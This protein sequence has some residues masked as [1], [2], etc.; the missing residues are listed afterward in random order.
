MGKVGRYRVLPK[1]DAMLT[2]TTKREVLNAVRRARL[3]SGDLYRLFAFLRETLGIR[4]S[5]KRKTLPKVLTDSQL[6]AYYTAIDRGGNLGH[7]VM[8]RLLFYTGLRVAELRAIETGDVDLGAGK[9]FIRQGKGKKDRYV[10]F[11]ESFRVALQAYM[12]TVPENSYLFESAQRRAYSTRRI[13]QIMAEY[14][15]AAD[16]PRV[17][18]HLL[19]H[20]L[21]TWLTRQ[22]LPDSAIQL[23][24][25]H[26]S[27]KSLEQYQHMALEHVERPYQDAM[28][29]VEI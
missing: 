23:I 20:Q 2:A 24:S 25:G 13:E 14:A 16:I 29:K 15:E 4:R 19:R 26:A 3:N 28:R 17:H 12:A 7:Q 9:I 27:K 21:F 22:G 8:L 18:P 11:P 1:V 6:D 10:L 5:A